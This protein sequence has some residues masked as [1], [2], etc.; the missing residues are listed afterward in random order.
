MTTMVHTE[1]RS[2]KLHNDVIYQL[3]KSQSSSFEHALVEAVMNAAD[4]FATQVN[5]AVY[6]RNFVIRDNGIG[7]KSKDEIKAWFE[8][9]GFPHDDAN[10]RQFGK[11]GLGRAQLWAF[12]RTEWLSNQFRMLVDIRN[13]GLDYDLSVTSNPVQGTTINGEFYEPGKVPFNPALLERKLKLFPIP[14]YLNGKRLNL[15]LSTV[16]WTYEDDNVWILRKPH[17]DFALEGVYNQGV[18]VQS[19]RSLLPKLTHSY[20]VVTKPGQALELNISRNEVLTGRC[21]LWAD[22]REK[23]IAL[24][25][26]EK[27]KKEKSLAHLRPD[28]S[29]SVNFGKHLLT[30]GWPCFGRT[31]ITSFSLF[32]LLLSG[33]CLA[34]AKA[35]QKELAL[36]AARTGRVVVFDANRL[37]EETGLAAVTAENLGQAINLEMGEALKI[38]RFAPYVPNPEGTQAPYVWSDLEALVQELSKVP[39]EIE[40]EELAPDLVQLCAK[41]TNCVKEM[42]MATGFLHRGY[43]VSASSNVS[44]VVA[45][46]KRKKT[47][48]VDKSFLVRLRNAKNLA[49]YP[50]LRELMFSMREAIDNKP[51]STETKLELAMEKL[52]YALSVVCAELDKP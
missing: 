49:R 42:L 4:A 35:E 32:Q 28:V 23:I 24:D 52:D 6:S 31:R 22:I 45:V 29:D 40:A 13:K 2:F 36:K 39:E 21:P 30:L 48:L 8:T 12:G 1:V 44:G 16:E 37:A 51:L 43:R 9:L 33:M 10:H 19:M 7:F 26:S 38:R 14:V 5:I 11:F 20:I 15:D 34:V 46:D 3:I 47:F 41:L 18:Y 25:K 17:K 50:L 27:K